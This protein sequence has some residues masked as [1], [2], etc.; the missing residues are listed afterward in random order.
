MDAPAGAHPEVAVPAALFATLRRELAK[1][2]GVLPTIHALHAAGYCVGAAAAAAFRT[3]RDEEVGHLPEGDFWARIDA[4]FTKRGWG[5]L[6]HVPQHPAVGLLTSH[7][8]AE[9]AERHDGEDVSC[10]FSTGFLSGLLTE[11]VGGPVAVL[12]VACRTRGDDTCSFAF[13]A[14]A[15]IHELYGKLLEGMDLSGA[16][17]GL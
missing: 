13:G 10:S 8:W 7:N 15:S 4:F 17:S 9:A 3:T 16:L 5:S 1:E 6:K 2:A 12:E 11:L 14:S